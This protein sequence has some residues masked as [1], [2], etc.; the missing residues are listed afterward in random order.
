MSRVE[1]SR[2]DRRRD[3]R[4]AIVRTGARFAH[5][6]VR[7]RHVVTDNGSRPGGADVHPTVGNPLGKLLKR[8]IDAREYV[9]QVNEKRERHGLPPMKPQSGSGR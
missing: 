5:P 8:E 2:R 9:R 6:A 3:S 1:R 4:N 7:G